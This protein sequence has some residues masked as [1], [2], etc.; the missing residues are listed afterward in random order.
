MTQ[1]ASQT[2]PD[3][4]IEVLSPTTDRPKVTY[5]H[6]GDEYVLIE[7]GEMSTDFFHNLRAMGLAEQAKKITGVLDVVPSFRAVMIHFDPLTLSLHELVEKMKESESRIG[8]V[9]QLT[10]PSRIVNLPAAF[11]DHTTTE[12]VERYAKLI[13]PGAPNVINGHNIEYVAIYNGVT[14]EDVIRLVTTTE[15]WVAMLGFWPGLP[16][17][18]PL[19]GRAYLTAPKYNPTRP[20]TPEGA[21]GIGGP[22]LAIYPIESP[23]GYQLLGRT[24]P[25]YDLKQ[26]NPAFKDNPVLLKPADRVRLTRVTDE[27]LQEI[28]RR[29]FDGTFR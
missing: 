27:D 16:F 9:E 28:R 21:F 7:Y 26:R 14:V 3:A 6:S 24:V 15:Y 2:L 1:L 18:L 22:V 19:D 17:A 5:R 10:I 13:R 23:G 12:Y 25:I 4:V 29:V 11:Q 8:D 20:W